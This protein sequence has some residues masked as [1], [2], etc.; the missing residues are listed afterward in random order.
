MFGG[1]GSNEFV[2]KKRGNLFCDSALP[3]DEICY[4]GSVAMHGITATALQA[5]D[6][7]Q[8]D[9]LDEL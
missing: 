7:E 1:K 9:D 6:V 2:N 8:N 4:D 5:K 3:N